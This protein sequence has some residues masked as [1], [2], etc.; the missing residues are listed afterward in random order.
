MRRPLPNL[1]ERYVA[2][3]LGHSLRRWNKQSRDTADVQVG[4]GNSSCHQAVKS[5]IECERRTD[6]GTLQCQEIR[7]SGDA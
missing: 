4:E 2:C 1:K 6:G 5:I 3:R 7:K